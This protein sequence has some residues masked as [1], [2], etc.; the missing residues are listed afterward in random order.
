MKK[1]SDS[2][3]K[4]TK[5]YDNLI[6]FGRPVH[7]QMISRPKYIKLSYNFVSFYKLSL[8]VLP[9]VITP[10]KVSLELITQTICGWK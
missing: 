9:L 4:E 7:F 3:Q 2:P 5:L 1:S 8:D 10:S 6:Y